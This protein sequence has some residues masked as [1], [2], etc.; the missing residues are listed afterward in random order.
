MSVWFGIENSPLW[1][2]Y[3]LGK[4]C[5]TFSKLY[6]WVRMTFEFSFNCWAHCTVSMRTDRTFCYR[7]NV[8]SR[9]WPFTSRKATWGG[10]HSETVP[11][12]FTW[13]KKENRS[14]CKK[15]HIFSTGLHL[16][17]CYNFREWKAAVWV[18]TVAVA[19]VTWLSSV[20]GPWCTQIKIQLY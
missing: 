16:P 17:Q 6:E 8:R 18:Y 3:C 13:K 5:S 15:F 11:I 14:E 20:N 1:I 4:S 7:I 10:G 12:N 2:S 9:K 19:G